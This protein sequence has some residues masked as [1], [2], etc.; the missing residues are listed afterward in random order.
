MSS[1]VA[2]G[3]KFTGL[4]FA[5]SHVT[6]ILDISICSRDIRDQSLKLS[7][8]APH[9]AR[10]WPPIFFLGGRVEPPEFVDLNY[11]LEHTSDHVGKFQGD[12][13]GDLALKKE[14]KWKKQQ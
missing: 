4:L 7:E 3:P 14:E 6:L 10:F 12:R 2:S 1:F 9:F 13:L 11:K 5:R 8:I